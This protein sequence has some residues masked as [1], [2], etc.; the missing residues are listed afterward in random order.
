MPVD[1]QLDGSCPSAAQRPK[2]DVKGKIGTLCVQLEMYPRH[3]A[4]S[5]G[6]LLPQARVISTRLGQLG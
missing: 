6:C 2:G 4:D 1:W 3:A 5:H